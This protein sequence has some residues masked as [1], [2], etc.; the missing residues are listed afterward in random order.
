MRLDNKVLFNEQTSPFV[1]SIIM[2]RRAGLQL[3]EQEENRF[4]KEVHKVHESVSMVEPP[5]Y[6]NRLKPQASTLNSLQDLDDDDEV[7]LDEILREM[8]YGE[9]DEPEEEVDMGDYDED[10]ISEYIRGIVRDD[11]HK[12]MSDIPTLTDEE[13]DSI[14]SDLEDDLEDDSQLDE[15]SSIGYK[16]GRDLVSKLRTGLFKT[17]DNNELEDFMDVLKSSF[18]FK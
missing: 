2:K 6:H 13:L 11:F 8:G 7:D 12:N 17:F 15:N 1:K 9:E 10:E 4:H 18:G 14:I 16:K 3:T 5:K